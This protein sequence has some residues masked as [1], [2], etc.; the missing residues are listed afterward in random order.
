[1]A[2]KIKTKLIESVKSL[3]DVR[4]LGQVFFAILILLVSWSGVKA[5]QKNYELQKQISKLQQEVEIQV[6]E[7]ANLNLSNQYLETDQFL[8][9]S[10][11][12]QFGKAAVGEKLLIVP[13]ETALKN[14]VNIKTANDK[15]TKQAK[16]PFY[17]ENFEDWISFFFRDSQNK[18]LEE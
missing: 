12:R 17:Q 15:Q 4:V 7:N 16:K 11:R 1:M 3:T 6:L 13:K 18:L 14:T 2:K 5:I 8:E 9:L 10:A